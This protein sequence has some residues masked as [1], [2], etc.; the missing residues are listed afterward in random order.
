VLGLGVL[1]R[2]VGAR[3]LSRRSRRWRDRDR[4]GRRGR[5]LGGHL[6]NR[7]AI[8]RIQERGVGDQRT[9]AYILISG[10]V[11][12]TSTAGDWIYCGVVRLGKVSDGER[13][14]LVRTPVSRVGLHAHTGRCAG[15][16]L[17]GSGQAQP[18]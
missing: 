5:T 2:V 6:R 13:G 10:E 1:Q 18:R 15:R 17:R 3:L 16:G 4:D 12:I 11:K 14:V 9:T 7:V 8:D